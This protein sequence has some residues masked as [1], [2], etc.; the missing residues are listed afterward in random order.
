LNPAANRQILQESGLGKISA[1]TASQKMV[2]PLLFEKREDIFATGAEFEELKHVIPKRGRIGVLDVF[3]HPGINGE[4]DDVIQA[5]RNP[6]RT[7]CG[8]SPLSAQTS[9]IVISE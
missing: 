6:D 9:L 8:S 3:V 7:S 4:I 5:N 1:E 2:D